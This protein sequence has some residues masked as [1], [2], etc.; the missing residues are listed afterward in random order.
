MPER[1]NVLQRFL[2]RVYA[3]WGVR[4]RKEDRMRWIYPLRFF[5]RIALSYPF[6]NSSEQKTY[7]ICSDRT[8]AFSPSKNE[9]KTF[10]YVTLSTSLPFD[11]PVSSSF[12]LASYLLSAFL[13]AIFF[14][15]RSIY[16]STFFFRHFSRS[17]FVGTIKWAYWV[18]VR[19]IRA[20]ING[21]RT[22]RVRKVISNVG[23]QF[24]Y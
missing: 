14:H 24:D 19:L 21:N 5:N 6:M 8:S 15:Q 11:M 13:L 10:R 16:L 4:D 9:T 2:T 3:Q 18:L 7:N 1:T 17:T 22:I 20:W 23:C 12:L